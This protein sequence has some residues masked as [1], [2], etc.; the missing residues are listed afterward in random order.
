MINTDADIR[1]DDKINVWFSSNEFAVM[2]SGVP[3]YLEGSKCLELIR[4]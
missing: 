2:L 1:T 4:G 3:A